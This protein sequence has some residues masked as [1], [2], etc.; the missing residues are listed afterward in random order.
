MAHTVISIS[1]DYNILT[2][3][4][5]YVKNNCKECNFKLKMQYQVINQ[6]KN[7]LYQLIIST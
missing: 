1:L 2:Q 7:W 3:P 6:V 5:K 4:Y